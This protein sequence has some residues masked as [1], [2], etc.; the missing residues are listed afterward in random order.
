MLRVCL[1]IVVTIP[2]TPSFHV[3]KNWQELL[4]LLSQMIFAASWRADCYLLDDIFLL[5]MC[6][7]GGKCTWI[8]AANKVLEMAKAHGFFISKIT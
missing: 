8:D 4:A 2:S 5:K 6:E 1:A 7:P 3:A